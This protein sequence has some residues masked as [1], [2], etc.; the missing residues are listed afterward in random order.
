MMMNNRKYKKGTGVKLEK[1]I[2]TRG[3]GR[4]EQLIYPISFFGMEQNPQELPIARL[5]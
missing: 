3:S 1:Q 4:G 5:Q 2:L